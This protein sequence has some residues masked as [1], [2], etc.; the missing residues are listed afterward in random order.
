MISFLWWSF[1]DYEQSAPGRSSRSTQGTLVRVANWLKDTALFE[2]AWTIVCDGPLR[3]W[4]SE[5][6]CL[7]TVGFWT[8]FLLTT[9]AYTPLFADLWVYSSCL[10]PLGREHGVRHVWAYMLF[11]QLVAIS[12]ASNLF[13]L[14]LP[15]KSEMKPR[16]STQKTVPPVLWLSVL[17][18]LLT[19]FLVPHS[20]RHDY[21]LSNLLIMHAL[22][23]IPLLRPV[24]SARTGRLHI[25]TRTLYQ[26][27]TLL[28]V[29]ARLRTALSM[30]TGRSTLWA[31]L[32]SHPA[33]ASIGWDVVWTTISFLQWVEPGTVA[34]QLTMISATALLSIGSS[35]PFAM[36]YVI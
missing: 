24:T 27:I 26:L 7:F 2:Q 14:A 31:V 12:V 11:G 20:L 3:W 22:L 6:L 4:W 5:Q 36:C 18:S 8:V 23:V 29:I 34:G 15:R 9:G 13:F 30:M 1:V 32:T 35:A 19:V 16:A 33:Q 10:L 17:A 28:A 25:R 21:L